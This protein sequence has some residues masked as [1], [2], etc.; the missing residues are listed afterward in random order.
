MELIIIVGL[1]LGLGLAVIFRFYSPGPEPGKATNQEQADFIETFVFP[2]HLV[3]N[4]Q[5]KYPHLSDHQISQVFVGLRDFFHACQKAG[6]TMVGMPSKVVDAAWHEFILD[7]RAYQ[8]F[9][10]QAFDRFLH[11]TPAEAMPTHANE[12]DGLKRA[13]YLTC[14]REG[15]DPK[16]PTRLPQLFALDHELAIPDGFSYS[17]DAQ[18]D[19]SSSFCAKQIGCTWVP[20]RKDPPKRLETTSSGR[21][22]GTSGCGGSCATGCLTDCGGGCGGD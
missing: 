21:R 10:D 15:I 19:D 8:I 12:Q 1:T 6:K 4:V 17:L 9:C 2:S 7:T 20:T 16:T 18:T 11:H 5:E 14:T 22:K 3:R 13:W